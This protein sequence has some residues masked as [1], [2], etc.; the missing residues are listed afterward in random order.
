MKSKVLINYMKRCRCKQGGGKR[1][2]VMLSVLYKVKR[3][4]KK[5][6]NPTSLKANRNYFMI[7]TQSSPSCFW[8]KMQ[9]NSHVLNCQM[10][11]KE[12][13]IKLSIL[14]SH[15]K[16]VLVDFNLFR[17]NGFSMCRNGCWIKAKW[18]RDR[19][20]IN[21]KEGFKDKMISGKGR[22]KKKRRRRRI[23]RK[24]F[25]GYLLCWKILGLLK[26]TYT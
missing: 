20:I 18:T 22:L 26:K 12:Q 2:R 19:G 25:R 21:Q 10:T 9:E 23:K 11:S 5:L 1:F 6:R 14:K 15:M 17:R 7:S 8:R 4:C 3:N 24:R 16:I 13:W